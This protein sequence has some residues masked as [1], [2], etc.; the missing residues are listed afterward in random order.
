MASAVLRVV[1]REARVYRRLWQSSVFSNFVAPVLFL[2]GMGVG[3]GGL[4][5]RHT[6]QVAGMSYLHFVT[7]GLLAGT[8]MRM[9]AGNSL[10]PVMAGTKWTRFFFGMVATPLGAADIFAGYLTWTAIRAAASSVAFLIAAAF[11]GGLGSWWAVLAVPPS[12]LTATAFAAPLTAFTA[13]Q[14]T[15]LGFSLILRL[16]IMPLF[17]FSGTFYP[18]S[19]LPGWL[20]PLVHVSPLWHGVELCRSATTGRLAAGATIEHLVVLFG[21]VIVGCVWG[22][23]SFTRRLAS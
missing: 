5:D 19:Q 16:V 21:L 13:T 7:P 3:L 6:G 20:R 11:L 18:V 22:R 14:E 10:W 8:V 17:V 4:V 1:E 2:A 23:Q 15:D 12:V 9:A